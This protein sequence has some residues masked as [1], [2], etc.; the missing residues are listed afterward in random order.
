MNPRSPTI[1]RTLADLY[2]EIGRRPLALEHSA[3]ALKLVEERLVDDP[4]SHDLRLQRALYAAK[5]EACPTALSVATGL[6]HELPETARNVHKLAQVYALCNQREEAL[7]A[8][9]TAIDLGVSRKLV[10]QESEFRALHDDP[11]FQELTED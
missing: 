3:A 6:E 10:L 11:E 8:I 2:A 4:G 7:R 9:R 1:Q 5:S